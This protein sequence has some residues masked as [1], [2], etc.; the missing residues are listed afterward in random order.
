MDLYVRMFWTASYQDMDLQNWT[1]FGIT[2]LDLFSR[3]N[4][5]HHQVW[6]CMVSLVELMDVFFLFCS[7]S[8]IFCNEGMYFLLFA[9][10]TIFMIFVINILYF[11]LFSPM[12][13]TMIIWSNC[14]P[15]TS[16]K[17][18]LNLSYPRVW[19]DVNTFCQIAPDFCMVRTQ[20][21]WANVKVHM[22]FPDLRAHTSVHSAPL[23]CCTM[24]KNA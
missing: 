5:Q 17:K 6:I 18:S 4:W 8:N 11:F 23:N 9:T 21:W 20:P 15:Q 19:M 1:F 2:I 14:Q 3:P 22:N 16:V 10:W 7:N 13:K 24:T 12:K